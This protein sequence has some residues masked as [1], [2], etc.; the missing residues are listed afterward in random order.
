MVE[1]WLTI[2]NIVPKED[3]EHSKLKISRNYCKSSI[4]DGESYAAFIAAR[5]D[6][7]RRKKIK[8]RY[9]FHLE[10]ASKPPLEPT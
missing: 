5:S 10:I 2:M 6:F 1:T 8:V 4:A 7:L 9:K 3:K